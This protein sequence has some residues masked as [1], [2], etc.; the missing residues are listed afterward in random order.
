LRAGT[1]IACRSLEEALRRAERPYQG[2]S[3]LGAQVVQVTHDAEA[4]EFGEPRFLGR[5][6][7]VPDA[8]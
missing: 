8:G 1:A 5:V 7:R 4:D 6:G 2:G 3:I